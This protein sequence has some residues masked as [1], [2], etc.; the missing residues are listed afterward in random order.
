MSAPFVKS[1]RAS[2]LA[3]YTVL[4]GL[5][6]LAGLVI[7]LAYE[8]TRPVVQSKR[9]A[10]MQAAVLQVLPDT[11]RFIG[12]EALA[13]GFRALPDAAPRPD[14]FAG[15]DAEGG[16]VGFAIP[17]RGMG[18]QD[19]ISLLYGLD[20]IAGV[21]LGLRILESRET[22]GLGDRIVDDPA[23]LAGFRELNLVLDSAGSSL[24]EPVALAT[25]RPRQTWEIDGITGATVSSRAVVRALSESIA[26][27]LPRL[28]AH[29]EDF[30][31]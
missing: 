17:A 21:V 16:L 18:Y 4:V 2:P 27:W 1:D 8:L 15:Y 5:A 26:H 12:Y 14:L 11:V 31:G 7:A 20:P 25:R 30:D 9:M 24:A 13:G 22:P 28:Q 10:Y 23:F 6:L 3:M 29:L 19:H